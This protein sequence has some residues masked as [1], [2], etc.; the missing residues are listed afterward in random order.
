M[1]IED[2]AKEFQRKK[3]EAEK[4]ARQ[5]SGLKARHIV[6]HD[7]TCIPTLVAMGFLREIDIEDDGAINEAYAAFLRHYCHNVKSDVR[8]RWEIESWVWRQ[9]GAAAM[10]AVEDRISRGAL[11][12]IS[13]ATDSDGRSSY[14]LRRGDNR[15]IEVSDLPRTKVGRKRGGAPNGRNPMLTTATIYNARGMVLGKYAAK[16][17]TP[18]NYPKIKQHSAHQ[19]SLSASM[20]D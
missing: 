7:E 6:V 1:N 15:P 10:Q 17:S 9:D 2:E 3:K 14:L 20:A 5:R 8:H 18:K 16:S 13:P 11:Q 19:R 12:R 4:K